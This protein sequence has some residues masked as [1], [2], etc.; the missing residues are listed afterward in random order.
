MRFVDV[1][2]DVA[3]RKIFGDENKKEILMSFLNAV[4]DLPPGKLIREITFRHTFQL[5]EVEGLRSSV[6]DLRVTD[7]RDITYIVE[8][9]VEQPEGFAKR[10]QY[11]TAKQYSTQI[12]QGDNYPALNQVIFIGILNFK[13]FEGKDYQTKHL[14]INQNTGNHDLKDLE[15]NFIELPKFTK[16]FEELV[17]LVDKWIYF[18]K[19]AKTMSFFPENIGDIG[20][21]QAYLSADT[22]SW[23]RDE[24]LIYDELAMKEQDKI[25]IM[26][27]KLRIATEKAEKKGME[28]RSM[29]IALEMLRD[30]ESVEKIMR[31]TGLSMEAI[32]QLKNK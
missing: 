26:T 2:N 29:A 16:S 30:G 15:F 32:M 8:T 24:L 25:G 5:P 19:H 22:H 3:F 23:S 27:R 18:F 17:T 12:N 10:V 9:Q 13:F 1:K 4:L 21:E 20:L 6:L 14:I 11:Y 28:K 7:Q 31:Y